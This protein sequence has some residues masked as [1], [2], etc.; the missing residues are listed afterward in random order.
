MCLVARLIEEPERENGNVMPKRTKRFLEKREYYGQ[1]ANITAFGKE[2][3]EQK[4]R[5]VCGLKDSIR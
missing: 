3:Y 2:E 5:V 1:V 4:V